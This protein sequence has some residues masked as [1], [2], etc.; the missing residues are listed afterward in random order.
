MSGVNSK[1]TPKFN[2][3]D[4]LKD[5][6]ELFESSLEKSLPLNANIHPG[7][8]KAMQYS[9]TAGGKRLRPILAMASC[10]ACGGRAEDVL[11][12]AVAIEFIHTYSLIHDDLPAMD[13]AELRRGKPTCHKVFGEAMA[14]LAGDA[15]LT[16]AF[17]LLAWWASEEKKGTMAC[18]LVKE[19]ASAAGV[20][21]MVSGQA[22]DLDEKQ[23]TTISELDKLHLLKTGAL[24][25]ASVRAGGIVA[26]ADRKKLQALSAYGENIGLAFQI[27]DDLL[28]EEG[29]DTGKDKGKDASSGKKTY[30]YFMG[31][32]NALKRARDL[33]VKAKK[34]LTIFG[35]KGNP[36]CAIAD[37]IVERKK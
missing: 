10:E 35:D 27:V 18:K 9:L 20:A 12:P 24:I 33:V 37:Y 19:I 26:K 8:L 15:L 36:L 25:K 1:V 4:Y 30:L 5:K 34:E 16:E 11:V 17:A 13:N 22:F 6:R 28:D 23:P 2:F 7:L 32:N 3:K 14:I 29:E 21:G 31:K